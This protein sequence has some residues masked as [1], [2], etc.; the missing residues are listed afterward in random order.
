MYHKQGVNYTLSKE[1]EKM[2][3]ENTTS[4]HS[5]TF[6]FFLYFYILENFMAWERF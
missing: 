4:Y 1:T 5:C 3:S 6:N 2:L